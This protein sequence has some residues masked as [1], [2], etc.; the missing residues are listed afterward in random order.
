MAPR[1]RRFGFTLI[2]LLVVI[3]ILAILIA[4][5]LAAIQYV[6]EAANR[7][8]CQNN[9]KQIGLALHQYHDAFGKFPPALDWINRDEYYL[10]WPARI[11][12]NIEQAPLY[13]TI[14]SEYARVSSPWGYAPTGP[15]RPHYGLG[16][17]MGLYGCPSDPRLAE[18][19][20]DQP[21]AGPGYSFTTSVGLT[22]YLGNAGT[23][24]T[25]FDGIFYPMST[26]R[27]TQIIDG[28]TNTILIGERPPSDDGFWGWWY[29]GS[30]FDLTGYADVTMGS[31]SVDYANYIGCS[32]V[33]LNFQPGNYNDPCAQLHWYSMHTGGANFCFADGSV[34]FLAY[35][36]AANAMVALG[37]RAGG[38]VIDVPID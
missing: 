5:L 23:T 15:T 38:E 36:A 8:Q 4:L 13:Q 20:T 19:A 12:P 27:L 14:S 17:V 30:G 37:T 35:S 9:M 26:I 18:L 22:S 33:Y 34:R 11:L 6:R 24:S 29:A 25:S 21:I 3:A 7:V 2:E 10:G 32:T 1:T 16:V 28:T 31:R